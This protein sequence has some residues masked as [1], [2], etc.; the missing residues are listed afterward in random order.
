MTSRVA[1]AW[2]R[3][4]SSEDLVKAA[5]VGGSWEVRSLLVPPR[6]GTVSGA[7]RY[8]VDVRKDMGGVIGRALLGG[9]FVPAATGNLTVICAVARTGAMRQRFR[10]PLGGKLWAG[11]P[12]DYVKG[13]LSAPIFDEGTVPGPG[14]LV[15][16][17]CGTDDLGTSD[18]AFGVATDV[19]VESFALGR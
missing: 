13:I 8:L 19:L 11:L 7:A 2:E 17:R 5:Y 4:I 15:I 18:M 10:A 3:S 1:D 12:T 6:L 16:D 9:Y 14:I